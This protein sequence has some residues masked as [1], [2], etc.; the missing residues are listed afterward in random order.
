M[1]KICILLLFTAVCFFS[2]C[3]TWDDTVHVDKKNLLFYQETYNACRSRFIH[4]AQEAAKRYP[5][6]VISSIPVASSAT[7][8]ISVDYV[9]LPALR[10]HTYLVVLTSGVHGAEGFA[11]SAAQHL[12]FSE[13][14]NRIDRTTTGVLI[15]HG[16]NPFGMKMFRRFTE[17]NID[18]NRNC[19]VTPDVYQTKNSG[20]EKLHSFFG[21]EKPVD[22]SSLDARAFS[23][24]LLKNLF[25]AGRSNFSQA[26]AGGQYQYPEGIFYGGQ[27]PES[28]V[29]KLKPIISAIVKE[30]TLIIGLDLHTGVGKR[31]YMHLMPDLPKD[32]YTKPALQKLYQGHPLD[33]P[34]SDDF[35][36]VTGGFTDWLT[37]MSSPAKCLPLTVEF[38]TLD[39]QTLKGGIKTVWNMVF[40][41][42]G[43]RFGYANPGDASIVTASYHEMF[44]PSS[45][46]WRSEVIAQSRI[47]FEIVVSRASTLPLN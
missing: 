18:I 26:M 2:S 28:Q 11:G 20:Y 29:E 41:N 42:Q 23:L 30:Y 15:I 19:P 10:Q 40:Q 6:T 43:R 22:L 25:A 9:Y 16:I 35:Y 17:N 46:A 37:V 1:K 4:D 34:D 3:T 38:G 12:F 21:P 36:P 27:N 8:N 5:G 44:F 7:S 14:L 47:L 24:R 13:Y 32:T 33:W 45:P 31:G 39:S